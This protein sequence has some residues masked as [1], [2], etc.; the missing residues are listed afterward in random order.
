MCGFACVSMQTSHDGKQ[1]MWDDDGGGASHRVGHDHHYQRSPRGHA[2]ASRCS[3][4]CPCPLPTT[5]RASALVRYTTA[6]STGWPY[7]GRLGKVSCWLPALGFQ[8]SEISDLRSD[9]GQYM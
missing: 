7:A 3:A 4:R 1:H 6:A 9:V 8:P 2:H 5:L